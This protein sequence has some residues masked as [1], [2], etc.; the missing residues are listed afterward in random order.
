MTR[1][2][3]PPVDCPKCGEPDAFTGVEPIYVDGT[4]FRD[5]ALSWACPRCG[6]ELQTTTA[7]PE[8]PA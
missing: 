7:N 3:P 5:D 6:Y 8:R 4:P 2:E 1:I